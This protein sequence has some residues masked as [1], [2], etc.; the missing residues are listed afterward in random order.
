LLRNKIHWFQDEN[1]RRIQL[2]EFRGMKMSI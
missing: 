1:F 2:K